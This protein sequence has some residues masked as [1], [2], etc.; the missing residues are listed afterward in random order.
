MEINYK[1]II[2]CILDGDNIMEKKK[3]RQRGGKCQGVFREIF[4]RGDICVKVRRRKGYQ[5]EFFGKSVLFF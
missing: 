1:N 5:L 2:Y 3:V 4:L